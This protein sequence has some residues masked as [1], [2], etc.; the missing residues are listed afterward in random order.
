MNHIH[1]DLGEYKR[2]IQF[3]LSDQEAEMTVDAQL[4]CKIVEIHDH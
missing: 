2:L 3:T 1:N 4:K